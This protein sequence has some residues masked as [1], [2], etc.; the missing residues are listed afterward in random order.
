MSNPQNPLNKPTLTTHQLHPENKETPIS[1]IDHD[2]ISSR[3]FYKR[4][5]FSYPTL[6]Y[7]NYWLPINGM[8]T[9][10][11]VFSLEEIAKFPSITTKVVMECAGNKRSLFKPLTFGEQWGKGAL[12]KVSGREFP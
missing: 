7:S 11:K 5:H 8:V 6:T 12:V 9:T 1:F 4:N 2:L 10:P 3:L